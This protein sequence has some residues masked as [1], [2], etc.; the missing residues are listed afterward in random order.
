LKHPKWICN[1]CNQTLTGKW[2]AKR[3]CYTYHEG[4]FDSIISFREYLTMRTTNTYPTFTHKI[5]YSHNNNHLPYQENLIVQN[6]STIIPSIDTNLRS[7]QNT[8]DDYKKGEMLLLNILNNI[9]PKYEE[10]ENLLSNIPEPDKT[11]ILGGIIS[12]AL[13]DDNPVEYI[14]NKLKELRKTMFSNKIL[15]AASVFL[16]IDKKSTK[17]H[18]IKGLKEPVL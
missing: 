8:K 7:T 4:L 3:H 15:E 2:N 18:L 6:K 14:N 16:G 1:I 13:Y 5:D 17:V 10:M 12:R 11:F 9:A